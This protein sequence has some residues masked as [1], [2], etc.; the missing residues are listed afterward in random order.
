MKVTT[1][2]TYDDIEELTGV[3]LNVRGD[4]TQ[5]PPIA[6][7]WSRSGFVFCLGMLIANIWF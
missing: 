4:Q 6:V 1:K 5:H 7:T 3:G 2:I